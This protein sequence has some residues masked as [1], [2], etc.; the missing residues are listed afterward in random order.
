MLDS[1]FNW[2]QIRK[3]YLKQL[4]QRI[5]ILPLQGAQT[6]GSE[7]VWKYTRM[8]AGLHLWMLFSPF[9]VCIFEIFSSKQNDL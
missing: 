9:S 5:A 7:A 4:W 1:K 6:I 8:L 3:K 2:K